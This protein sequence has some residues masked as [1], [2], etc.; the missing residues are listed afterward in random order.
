MRAAEIWNTPFTFKGFIKSWTHFDL[1]ENKNQGGKERV[2]NL[3]KQ[4]S[5]YLLF[6]KQTYVRLRTSTLLRHES[7]DF[8]GFWWTDELRN[9]YNIHSNI[10]QAISV[11]ASSTSF[12]R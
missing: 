7:Q 6:Y 8:L 11:Q 2:I 5:S 3:W 9:F 4:M 1:Y 12:H 10:L